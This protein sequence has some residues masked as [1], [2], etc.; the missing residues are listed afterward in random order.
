MN[1]LVVDICDGM[2]SM[3]YY[4]EYLYNIIYIIMIYMSVYI[5]I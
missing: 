2:Y 1:I 5:Y 4:N 3:D